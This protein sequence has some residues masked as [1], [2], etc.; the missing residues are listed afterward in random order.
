MWRYLL[1]F[2]LVS[3]GLGQTAKLREDAFVM[4]GHV[5]MINRQ[6]YLGGDITDS[7]PDGQVDVPRIRRG[8]LKAIFFSLFSSEEYYPRR[9]E[10]KHTLRLMDF[11]LRQLEKHSDVMEIALRASDI[12]RINKAG[13]IAAVLDLEGGFDLD[14]D[15]ALLRNLYRL[16]LRSAML[17]AHNFTNNFADSCCAPPKWNGMNERGRTVVAE[18]NRLGMVINVAHGSNETILQAAEISRDPVLFSH[19]GSR[20][21]VDTPRNL[22]DEAARKIASKGGVIGLQF[23]NSFSNREYFEWRQKGAPFGDLTGTLKRYGAFDTIEALDKAV[24]M[25]YPSEPKSAPEAMRMEIGRLVEVIDYWIQLV[26]ED[27]VSLGSDFDGGPEPPRGMRDIADY[28]QITAAMLRKG[29][30]E[31]R[32]RKVL[33]LNLLSLFRKVTERR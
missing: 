20:H 1:A 32:I 17:V 12:E 14:G 28:G 16:G 31:Q 13:K 7:Y 5:H 10:V 27:H 30:S 23:G 24:A 21:F 18:M 25:T 26:G 15:P 6:F 8:G 4:D 19:G 9:F 33:G 22:S 11:A 29:Y 2:A 3:C